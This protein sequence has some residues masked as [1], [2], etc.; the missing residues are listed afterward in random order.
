MAIEVVG[1]YIA[2]SLAIM[3]DVNIYIYINKITLKQI[4]KQ[5]SFFITS[6]SLNFILFSKI[7]FIFT[8]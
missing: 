1:G 3:T 7:F 8:F 2:N 6:N 4:K 5:L